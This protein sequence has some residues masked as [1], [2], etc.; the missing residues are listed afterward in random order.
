VLR[1]GLEKLKQKLQAMKPLTFELDIDV[2]YSQQEEPHSAG[3][4]LDVTGTHYREVRWGSVEV[5]YM[6]ALDDLGIDAAWAELWI[7]MERI[8][9]TS[10]VT[11]RFNEVYG[12]SPEGLRAGLLLDQELRG[13]SHRQW[14]DGARQLK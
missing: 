8:C 13:N 7:T 14:Q 1:A 11:R 4:Y 5:G 12:L 10:P 2:Y 9:R 3:K 6:E